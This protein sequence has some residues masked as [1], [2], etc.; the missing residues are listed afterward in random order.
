MAEQLHESSEAVIC[1]CVLRENFEDERS[2][3]ANL[4]SLLAP[5]FILLPQSPAGTSLLLKCIGTASQELPRAAL[6]TGGA[7]A[8]HGQAKAAHMLGAVELEE[9]FNPMC[10]RPARTLEPPRSRSLLP[11]P[12]LCAPR[13]CAPAAPCASVPLTTAAA[14]L[15]ESAL[16]S[17]SRSFHCRTGGGAQVL[18]RLLSPQQFAA[19]QPSPASNPPA[20]APQ[21]QARPPHAGWV[22]Q[23]VAS[24]PPQQQPGGWAPPPPAGWAPQQPSPPTPARWAPPQQ[25]YLHAPAQ[26][27]AG[28]APYQPSPPAPAQP[29][30]HVDWTTVPQAA[31]SPPR[32]RASGP[33]G[34]A[35]S[36]SPLVRQRPG[37]P[38]KKKMQ[39][40]QVSGGQHGSGSNGFGGGDSV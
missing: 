9:D 1:R 33:P 30:Q 22:P 4:R 35:A 15:S 37:A 38:K 34:T 40:I 13:C 2:L 8:E 6:P 25:P 19:H 24:Q 23:R 12:L 18:A 14:S 28:W 32:S 16:A 31:A 11:R 20:A 29:G 3:P 5:N 21:M 17:C 10:A 39:R 36:S 26:P 7:A 27:P